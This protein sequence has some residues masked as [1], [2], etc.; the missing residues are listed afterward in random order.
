MGWKKSK[1]SGL[2]RPRGQGDAGPA[3]VGAGLLA[4]ALQFCLRL[5]MAKRPE[6][7]GRPALGPTVMLLVAGVQAAH[8][9]GAEEAAL[10]PSVM[11][12]QGLQAGEL[13]GQVL[14][15]EGASVQHS[16]SHAWCWAPTTPLPHLKER[17]KFE[18]QE[19][20]VLLRTEP[21]TISLFPPSL[22]RTKTL[23]V[24]V[25]VHI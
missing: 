10:S 18:L 19:V 24:E 1:Q 13:S 6:C 21:D 3:G 25:R 12:H 2:L 20:A 11:L 17:K 7:P 9:E 4:Q 23:G 5:G 16:L 14:G 15:E 22:D 8:V